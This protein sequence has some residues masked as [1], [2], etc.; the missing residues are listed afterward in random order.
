MTNEFLEISLQTS[1]TVIG[2]LDKEY[3]MQVSPDF[4]LKEPQHSEKR[5]NFLMLMLHSTSSAHF[6][7]KMPLSLNFLESSGIDSIFFRGYSVVDESTRGQLAA[8]LAGVSPREFAD[9]PIDSLPWLFKIAK[10]HGYATVL[11]NDKPSSPMFKDVLSGFKTKPVHHYT[12]PFWSAATRYS[13]A[14]DHFQI[15]SCCLVF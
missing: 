3:V 11:T 5:L 7:R 6:T 4:D 15:Y 13:G 1:R 14:V 2:D 9:K 12:Q 8:L 10:D